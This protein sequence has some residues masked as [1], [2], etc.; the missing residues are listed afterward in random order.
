MQE[1]NRTFSAG[2]PAKTN[3]M[4]RYHR[5]ADWFSQ[6][7]Y[8]FLCSL[9]LLMVTAYAATATENT[10]T[11]GDP[12]SPS[13]GWKHENRVAA[14][15]CFTFTLGSLAASPQVDWEYRSM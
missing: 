10:G 4:K 15:A 1:R 5:G 9:A 6:R 8:A 13:T 7:L 14:P 2:N 12:S 11:F 3:R